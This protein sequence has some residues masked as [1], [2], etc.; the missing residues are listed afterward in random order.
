M[1]I[2]DITVRTKRYITDSNTYIF[3]LMTALHLLN[4]EVNTTCIR[5]EKDYAIILRPL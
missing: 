2:V 1:I 4:N 5:F 3:N